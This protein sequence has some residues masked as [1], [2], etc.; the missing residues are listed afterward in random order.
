MTA[1]FNLP[2]NVRFISRGWL[3]SNSILFLGARC[4]RACWTS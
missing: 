4:C 2:P 3:N 1:E